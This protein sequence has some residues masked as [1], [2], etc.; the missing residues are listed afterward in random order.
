MLRRIGGQT[1]SRRERGAAQCPASG[2]AAQQR[3]SS[4][5]ARSPTQPVCLSAA[6]RDSRPACS[7]AR[8]LAGPLAPPELPETPSAA[9]PARAR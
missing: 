4:V 8:P 7:P 2:A 5:A 1:G 6:D 9:S 3:K